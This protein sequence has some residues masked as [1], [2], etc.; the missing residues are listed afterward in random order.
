M[1][2]PNPEQSTRKRLADLESVVESNRSQI[3]DLLK[4][5]G[6]IGRDTQYLSDYVRALQAAVV[7]DDAAARKEMKQSRQ[8]LEHLRAEIEQLSVLV[9]HLGRV[10]NIV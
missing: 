8:D 3:T 2:F 6:Q 9:G 7:E 1:T 10:L 5:M 4:D